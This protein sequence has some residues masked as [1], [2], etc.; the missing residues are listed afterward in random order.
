MNDPSAGLGMV[1]YANI[2]DDHKRAVLGLNMARLL[3]RVSIL[4]QP[5]HRWLA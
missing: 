2:P 3:D 5:L 1:V 4:P